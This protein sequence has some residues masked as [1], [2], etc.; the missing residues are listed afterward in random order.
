MRSISR[1]TGCSLNTVK[2]LLIDAGNTCAEYHD[3]FVRD[4]CP[5]RIEL[6]EIWPFT[7]AKQ[8]NVE[9]A[10]SAPLLPDSPITAGNASD[11]RG[12]R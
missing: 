8:A 6:D 9:G 10:K 2:K 5:R 4:L 1:L 12:D 7:Y 11:G 3:I